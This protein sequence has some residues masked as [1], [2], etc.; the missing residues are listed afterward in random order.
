M[1]NITF[2]I[3]LDGVTKES[4]YGKSHSQVITERVIKTVK[5]LLA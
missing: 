1:G 5:E 3:S 2:Q 4:N